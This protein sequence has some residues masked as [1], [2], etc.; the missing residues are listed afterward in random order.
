MRVA[1]RR[2]ALAVCILAL[3]VVSRLAAA[4]DSEDGF[5]PIFDG[6]SLNGWDGNPDIWSIEDNAITGQTRADKPLKANSF[7]I[8]RQGEVDDFELQLEFRMFGGNSG[9]QYRSWE[10]PENWGK[11]VIGGYQADMEA[12]PK[13]TGILYG[14]RYR[15]VL[16]LRG[17]KTVIGQDH[18]PKLVEQFADSDKL[19]SAVKQEDWNSYRIVAKGYH[20]IQEINGQKT[21]DVTDEDTAQR[22]RSGLLA[23]QVHVGKPMKVQFRNIRLKRLP[24]EDK[25]KVVFIAGPKSHG[26]ASHELNAGSILLAKLLSQNVPQIQTAVY[27]NGWPKDPTALDNADAIVL[28]VDGGS[29]NPVLP[30]LEEVGRL[31]KKGVGLAA[32]HYAVE[33]PKGEPGND[34]LD[35]I[36]GYFEQFW[37]VNP[38]FEAKVT[39]AN[40]HPITRGVKP[41]TI[42]DEWYY[43]MRFRENM[44]GVTPIL[45]TIP[46]DNTRQGADGPHSGNPAVRAG[47]GQTE[48]L[49][50][51]RQRPDGGRGFGFTGG[52]WHWNW[53]HDEF[54]KLVLNAVVWTAGL[55][56]PEGGVP[57][58]TPTLQE[59]ELNIDEPQPANFNRRKVEQDLERFNQP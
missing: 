46:P 40:D 12:G 51:A 25:K 37:S 45:T 24:L 58:K 53:G 15:D 17:Q 21:V 42:G 14:E 31:M 16:A 5:R 6:K 59:L 22:R 33:V 28:F 8:W 10:E 55:D 50:W 32:L 56:V 44:E 43:H 3:A 52:H 36:G 7:I 4:A 49:A 48:I 19:Q 41:F 34:F 23:F 54:R 1:R 2:T 38:S 11:W 47:K 20:F 30:H 13:Y 35:W 9:I 26:Y 39:P 27:H 57:S 29:G 18:K